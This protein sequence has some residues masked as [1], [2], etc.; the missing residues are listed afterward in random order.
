MKTL[1]DIRKFLGHHSLKRKIQLVVRKRKIHNF[2][3]AKKAGLI[4]TCN[5]EEDFDAVKNFKKYLEERKI[6][7]FALGYINNKTIPDHFLLRTGF[8]FFSLK[9]L[10]WYF[11]PKSQFIKDF[12]TEKFDI[13]FDLCTDDYFPVHYIIS[14]SPA[15][16][17]IGRFNNDENYDL[18]IETGKNKQISYLVDQIKHYLNMIHSTQT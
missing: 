7:T 5:S 6:K 2:D 4:F 11:R 17:K 8:N 12:I 14:L 18:M 13:L 3:T 9:N 10:D 16:Y 1:R 15:E